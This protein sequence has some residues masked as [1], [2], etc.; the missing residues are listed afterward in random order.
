MPLLSVWRQSSLRRGDGANAA[1]TAAASAT[2]RAGGPG[3]RSGPPAAIA[4]ADRDG[5]YPRARGQR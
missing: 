4:R 5:H 3:P 2:A 1:A